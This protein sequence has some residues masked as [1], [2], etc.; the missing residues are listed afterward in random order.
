M[1]RSS[2][3]RESGF[4]PDRGS[5]KHVSIDHGL[6]LTK[7][8]LGGVINRCVSGTTPHTTNTLNA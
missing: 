7:L 6:I 8:N 3:L 2:V 1:K 4:P 5:K